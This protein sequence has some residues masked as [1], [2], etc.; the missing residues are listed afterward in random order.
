MQYVKEL[1]DCQSRSELEGADSLP[2][3][4]TLGTMAGRV[5]SSGVPTSPWLIGHHEIEVLPRDPGM[6]SP[7]LEAHQRPCG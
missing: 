5:L 1:S 3:G 6:V 2:Q 7:G 4:P